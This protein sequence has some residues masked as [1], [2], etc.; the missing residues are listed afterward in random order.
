MKLNQLFKLL[1]D[2]TFYMLI[3]VVVLFPGTILYLLI[4]P[5]QQIITHL[6][7]AEQGVGWETV[8]ILL[9]IYGAYLLFFVGFYNLRKFTA[10]L[11]K[12]RL[13]KNS[14]VQC[15][16]RIGQ[17]FTGCGSFSLTLKLIY[18]LF[19][20]TESHIKFGVSDIQ[21]YLFL[22]IIGVFFLILSRAFERALQMEEESKLTI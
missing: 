10:L 9:T 18:V 20:S 11:L 3:P 19:L 7:Y 15:T 5:G 2:I 1:I 4:F 14:S 13:F 22:I 8:L 17:F 6:P 12:D 16:K 21:L